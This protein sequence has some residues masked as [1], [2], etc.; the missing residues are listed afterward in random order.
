MEYSLPRDAPHRM[1]G[2]GAISLIN[3][4]EGVGRNLMGAMDAPLN[5]I[6][7]PEGPHRIAGN[8]ANW[9]AETAKTV[10]RK[11]TGAY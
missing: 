8:V 11:V 9:G 2:K 4:A 1:V 5:S 6:K 3:A 7:G 10:V